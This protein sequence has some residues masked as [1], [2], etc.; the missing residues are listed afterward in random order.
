MFPEH[1]QKQEQ[2]HKE[3]WLRPC[4]LGDTQKRCRGP[5]LVE[6]TTNRQFWPPVFNCCF[7]TDPKRGPMKSVIFT[8]FEK[9]Y[10]MGAGALINSLVRVGFVGQIIAG[11]RGEPPSWTRTLSCDE[12]GSLHLPGGCRVNLVQVG[13]S[14][15]LA[16]RKPAFIL[17]QLDA[18]SPDKIFYFDPDIILKAK[19]SFFEDWV[20]FGVAACQDADDVGANH[21]FRQGWA[22]FAADHGNR[23][24][25]MPNQML[26]SGFFGL[27]VS[28]IRF[29]EMWRHLIEQFRKT[30]GIDLA[31]FDFIPGMVLSDYRPGY[32]KILAGVAF[33]FRELWFIRNNQDLMNL[34]LMCTDVEM[35]TIGRDGM[36]F[37]ESGHIMSHPAGTPMKPWRKHVFH[38]MTNAD[39]LFWR[40]CFAPMKIFASGGGVWKAQLMRLRSYC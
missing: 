38:S 4:Y 22:R 9:D 16:H 29:L 13:G 3:T 33:P 2:L 19:W 32:D 27:R 34:S 30:S 15:F 39:R 31:S 28:D 6:L 24:L 14:D 12:T 23:V 7:L 10:S 35:S 21:P 36:D 17:S 25:R 18:I 26:N 1:S 11:Y 8:L 37:G 20:Q 40:H 5:I